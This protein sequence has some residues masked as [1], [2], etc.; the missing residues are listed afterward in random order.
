MPA[1]M[2]TA[3]ID[4]D[5]ARADT[6]GCELVV[7]LNHA[8]TSLAPQ[9]VL[10]AQIEW[11]QAEALTGGYELAADREADRRAAYA[12]VAALVGAEPDEIALV[13]NATFAWH[14]A[15]WSLPLQPGDRIL[16]CTVEYASSYLSYLQAERRRGV[17]IEAIPDD[18]DGQLSLRALARMLDDGRAPVGLVAVTQVPTNG[19]LVNPVAEVG[20][21]CR[22]AG[23][24][25][26]LDAC[27]SVGQMPV[28]VDEIGCDML[29]ATGRKF[30]R[31]PRGTG[32]LYV[33][34]SLLERLDRMGAEPAFLDLLGADWVAPDGY[35][36]RP[37]ARRF[38]NWESNLAAVAGLRAAVAYA[39]SWGL[40][41]IAERVGTVAESLRG[42]LGE[43][44]G[45][46]VRDLGRHRSGI[47]TFT[48]DSV[49]ADDV[50]S[51]LR[52][53]GI[54]VSVSEP[55]STRLDAERRRLPPLVRA[56]VHY[57]TTDAELDRLTGAVADLVAAT[58]S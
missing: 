15:F 42:R 38:E 24:P 53:Q 31:A 2:P 26:L 10:D 40:D 23:V 21:L 25:F 49:A 16:T 4:V 5:R 9:P 30:L 1:D 56:S 35:E 47:V 41:A 7:H 45:V 50:Q 37:D 8:G 57:V 46:L 52:G 28:E 12:E 44:P 3:P 51:L 20:A 48:V 14:Q 43:I 18:E 29:S 27:Q 54:N 22:E 55:S 17:S 6:P 36:L 19:G 11:L 39:R 32:F 34:R 13:E 33:R 58:S